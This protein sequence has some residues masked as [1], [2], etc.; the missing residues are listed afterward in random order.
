M[1]KRIAI[2]C[3]GTWN[4]TDQANQDK[5]CPTNVV[6]LALRV[7]KRDQGMSQLVYYGQGVGTGYRFLMLNYELDAEHGR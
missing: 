5:P 2:F 1:G 6:K 7:A 4:S 3:D